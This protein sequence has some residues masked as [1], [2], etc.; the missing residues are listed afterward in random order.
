MEAQQPA[1]PV[2]QGLRPIEIPSYASP[3]M[4]TYVQKEAALAAE[5]QALREQVSGG[6][7]EEQR[8]QMH[9][10]HER[11]AKRREAQW[12]EAEVLSLH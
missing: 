5:E 7:A 1:H 6:S 9:H 12:R 3:R 4:R 2:R 11:T 8:D 10:F